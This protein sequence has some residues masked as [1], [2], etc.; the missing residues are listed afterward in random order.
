MN[1]NITQLITYSIGVIT[2][3][4]TI[5]YGMKQTAEWLDIY[6]IIILIPVAIS[7]LLLYSGLYK[8][9]FNFLQYVIINSSLL[10]TFILGIPLVSYASSVEMGITTPGQNITF[11]YTSGIILLINYLIYLSIVS[12]YIVRQFS[13]KEKK[14]ITTFPM[15]NPAT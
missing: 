7:A 14:T 2:F 9:Q 6:G 4:I 8:I 1:T 11:A 13:R 3:E 10:L 15:A 12:K 5:F